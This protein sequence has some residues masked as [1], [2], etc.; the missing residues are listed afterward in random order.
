MTYSKSELAIGAAATDIALTA[1]P[2][3]YLHTERRKAIVGG[4]KPAASADQWAQLSKF[5]YRGIGKDAFTRL[6]YKIPTFAC[7]TFFDSTFGRDG[8]A[9]MSTVIGAPIACV[10]W[11]AAGQFAQHG[12]S[13]SL[14]AKAPYGLMAG[15]TSV[16]KG[17]F[18]YTAASMAGNRAT[19][20]LLEQTLDIPAD[21]RKGPQ[22]FA[23]AAAGAVGGALAA[24]A[25]HIPNSVG[26]FAQLVCPSEQT[27][28]SVNPLKWQDVFKSNAKR[29]LV[30]RLG[31]GLLTGAVT[32]TLREVVA[33]Q[34][35]KGVE[36]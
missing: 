17:E 29:A 13:V 21:T 28:K 7:S 11:V 18:L 1:A 26:G 35:V 22:Y 33:A 25:S 4:L 3:S 14:T 19:R 6:G 12:S 5:N 15:Y 23:S 32:G 16:L 10:G 9:V 36:R 8:G 31:V 24:V 34:V 2:L 30:P 20:H 27:P